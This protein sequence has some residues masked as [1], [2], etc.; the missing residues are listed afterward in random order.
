MSAPRRC[1]LVLLAA[2]LVAA[3]TGTRDDDEDRT[4]TTSSSTT[5]EAPAVDDAP[6][7][8]ATLDDAAVAVQEIARLEDP[9]GFAARPSSPNLYVIEKSGRVRVIAVTQ[10]GRDRPPRYEVQRTPIL[11]LSDE[12]VAQGEQGLLGIAFSTDGRHLYLDYTAEPDGRTVVV[13]YEMGDTDRVDERS[14]RVLLEVPQPY[15]NHNGG[16]LVTGRDGFLYIGLGDGGSAGDPQGNGQDPHALLGSILRIDPLGG[17][18][19]VPY[20]VPAGNP[21]AD[22]DDGAP[23]VWLYGV[24]NPWRFAFDRATGDL[25]VADVG[26][27]EWEE[28][29][30]LPATGGFD[31]GKGA[32]LGW[33][34]VEGTHRFRGENP[35]GGVLPI[36][37]Y[38]HEDGSCSITGGV[39]YRG[40][41][42]PALQGAYLFADFCTPGL[43]A[44]QAHD[45]EVLAERRWDDLPL[46]QVQSF[47]EDADGEVYVLLATGPVLKLVAG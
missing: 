5:T 34:R 26:Q 11:D 4:T 23:E 3:C 39:V 22:G 10:T 20:V 13:E 14:R 6:A 45:G 16:H 15:P 7:V 1:L 18:E 44:I 8:E 28:I 29:T 38:G 43:R 9:V 47:G 33:S 21:F 27:D 32:N 17:A 19:E 12:V 36:F 35:A 40:E 46:E 24:R 2:G 30:W 42:I 41:A 31:A 37:E 25:W